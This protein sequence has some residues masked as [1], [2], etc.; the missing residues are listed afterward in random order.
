[1]LLQIC[2]LDFH[3]DFLTTTYFNK[4]DITYFSSPLCILR[5]VW[6]HPSPLLDSGEK[7]DVVQ[8]IRH[9][10]AGGIVLSPCSPCGQKTASP[11]GLCWETAVKAGGGL[12]MGENLPNTEVQGSALKTT[13][14]PLGG[15]WEQA[16]AIAVLSA[17][18]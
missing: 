1:M 11:R 14:S 5:N 4:R 17:L 10:L 16:V 12:Q 13:K 9:R 6:L 2:T 7:Q 3:F 8:H 15:T 18:R